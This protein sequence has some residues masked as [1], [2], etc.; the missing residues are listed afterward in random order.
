M[1]V[2]RLLAASI[3][4]TQ[5]EAHYARLSV[6][7]LATQNH[8][9]DFF[10]FF[11]VV[12]GNIFHIVSGETILLSEGSLVFIRPR[13]Q[14]YYQRDKN[15]ECQIINLAVFSWTMESVFDYLGREQAVAVLLSADLPPVTQ[16]S[17]DE[18][19]ALTSRLEALNRLPYNRKSIIRLTLRALLVDLCTNYFLARTQTELASIPRWL[20]QL[21]MKMQTPESFIE[22]R[23][24]LLGFANRSPEHVGR[25]FRKYLNLTPSEY[26]NSLRLNYAAN[27]LL[28]TD[29][30]ILDIALDAGFNNISYFNHLFKK[31]FH[32]TPTRFR[33]GHSHNIIP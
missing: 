28:H 23:E 16:L 8:D 19:D 14:H 25:A 4:D 17:E 3:L 9:H 6:N 27:L 13:D 21:C 22:G 18:K 29:R 30:T 20:A 12:R 5:T 7:E 15:G 26:V 10:E 1:T 32:T 11:L 31:H 33:A 24:A 2:M